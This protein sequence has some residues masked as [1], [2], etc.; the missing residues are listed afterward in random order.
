MLSRNYPPNERIRETQRWAWNSTGGDNRNWLLAILSRVSEHI[1][2]GKDVD[3]ILVDQPTV[4]HIMPRKLGPAWERHLGSDHERIHKEQLNSLGNLTLVTHGWNASMSNNS[5]TKKRK[6]LG[7]HGL[8]LNREYFA[9]GM[10][11][12]CQNWEEEQISGRRDWLVEY[13][14]EIW[15]DRLGRKDTD[16]PP[17]SIR[18]PRPGFKYTNTGAVYLTIRENSW[19]I[20]RNSW[21]NLAGM[22][23]DLVAVPRENFAELV[24]D[25]PEVLSFEEAELAYTSLKN[26]MGLCYMN[27]DEVAQYLRELAR[28]CDLDDFEWYITV[29]SYKS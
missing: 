12:D 3:I 9:P 22:F 28:L 20:P 16:L 7:T 5:W 27:P 6:D 15:P 21:N 26:G 29:K 23:T 14:L 24:R 8:P 19:D 25:L 11:G 1:H 4:E 2:S 18:H 17:D 10:P 13:T